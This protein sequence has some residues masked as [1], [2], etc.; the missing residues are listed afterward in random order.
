MSFLIAQARAEKSMMTMAT[1]IDE[2]NEFEARTTTLHRACNAR[3]KLPIFIIA[4]NFDLYDNVF[5]W[6][7]AIASQV[8]GFNT[9]A[10]GTSAHQSCSRLSH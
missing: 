1:Y 3:F 5:R 6:C 4:A 7:G 10:G 9:S 8:S 2:I